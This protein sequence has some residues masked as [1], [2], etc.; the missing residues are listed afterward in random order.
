MKGQRSYEPSGA[1]G[2][3]QPGVAS[4]LAVTAKTV[5]RG[6]FIN[7]GGQ[8]RRIIDIR[9]VHGGRQLRL[10]TGELLVIDLNGEYA[11]T[12]NHRPWARR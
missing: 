9:V 11:I 3:L 1:V 7:I 4:V 8:E 6:D 10:H 5:Q 12:R 2:R